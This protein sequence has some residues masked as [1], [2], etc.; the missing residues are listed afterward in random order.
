MHS[1]Y[2]ESHPAASCEELQVK[3]CSRL[4]LIALSNLFKKSAKK[5]YEG[6][7][8]SVKNSIDKFIKNESSSMPRGSANKEKRK[9]II[10]KCT[11]TTFRKLLPVIIDLDDKHITENIIEDIKR[12]DFFHPHGSAAVSEVGIVG[13]HTI[14]ETVLA[15]N[16]LDLASILSAIDEPIAKYCL[17]PWVLDF[18]SKVII[19]PPAPDID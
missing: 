7:E 2:K 14:N 11:E 18:T 17:K 4:E 15:S 16:Q 10:E 1:L 12:K 5:A 6:A 13:T 3:R 19:P 8:E 9:V